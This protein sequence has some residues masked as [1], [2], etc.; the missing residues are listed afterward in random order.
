M[1]QSANGHMGDGASSYIGAQKSGF[2]I[3]N[4]SAGDSCW[5]SEKGKVPYP[6][7]EPRTW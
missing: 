3:R 5:A 6:Q 2:R 1:S 4:C 7:K